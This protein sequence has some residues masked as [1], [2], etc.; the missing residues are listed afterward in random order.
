VRVFGSKNLSDVNRQIPMILYANHSYWWDGFWSQLCN[1]AFLN[2]NLFIII[3][4]KQLI[5]YQFFRKLG[6]FSIV[7][8]NPK[9]AI[10]TINYAV[11]CLL[12]PSQIPNGLWIFPQGAI[13][14][15]EKRPLNFF[16]GTAKIVEKILQK[17][18]FTRSNNPIDM[19]L[20]C[21]NREMFTR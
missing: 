9:E 6:A 16:N 21:R 13:E 12:S 14:P 17:R 18:R 15:I 3:E 11:E 20:L 4:Y 8:E 19:I 5:R 1:E 7:R 2:Q 10:Q